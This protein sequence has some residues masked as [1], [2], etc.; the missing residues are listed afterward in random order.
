MT[1]SAQ[2]TSQIKFPNSG[3][4][5]AQ[6]AFLKGVLLLHSFEYED[7]AEAFQQAQHQDPGFALAYWGEA[8]TYNHPIWGTPSDRDKAISC[9]NKLGS[10][11]AERLS[12]A[13]SDREKGLLNAVEALYTGPTEKK[14]RESAYLGIMRQLYANYPD[15]PEVASFC[16][17]AYMG[18][19][20]I[21]TAAE[22]TKKVLEKE[23][24]HP[25]ALH[26]FIHCN[27]NASHAH[28]ALQA[29]E[30]YPK[31]APYAQH[32]LHMPS[33]IFAAL[34]LWD[35][36]VASNIE[37]IA[38]AEERRKR[39]GLGVEGRAYHSIWWLEHG[40]LQQGR[41]KEALALVKEVENNASQ[42]DDRFIRNNLV[43]MR[44][45]YIIESRDWENKLLKRPVKIDDLSTD[46]QTITYFTDGYAAIHKGDLSAAQKCLES[47][48]V[49]VSKTLKDQPE[50][51][52]H[53]HAMGNATGSLPAA[54]SISIV[55]QKELQALILLKE[56]K[57]AEAEKSLQEA[58]RNESLRGQFVVPIF[59]KPARELMGEV[60]LSLNRPVEAK[61][62]FQSALELAPNR[63]LSLQG[64]SKAAKLSGDKKLATNT[65]IKIK[66]I[67]RKADKM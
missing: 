44:A 48:N 4:P 63:V 26:Y 35:G 54:Y 62:E 59:I 23:P 36:V 65:Q 28:L 5:L 46:N 32:A 8:M 21:D 25:G 12:K 2:N 56:S 66:A 39:K 61:Q 14:T 33:H 42:S 27:D 3:K 13:A 45:H 16:A 6:E 38:A 11:T 51:G 19:N 49:V 37:S 29:A 58:I 31:A 41:Y 9:L 47:I 43:V 50:Q 24:Y 57:W 52:N 22:I 20:I 67:R 53:S 64:L 17:L 55:L 60:L 30:R 18:A 34:G 40:Y 1:L 7:A 10:N 15:D